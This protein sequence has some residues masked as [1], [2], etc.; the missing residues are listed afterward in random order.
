MKSLATLAIVLLF[1][2]DL[3]LS[4][5]SEASKVVFE[6]IQDDVCSYADKSYRFELYEDGDHVKTVDFTFNSSRWYAQGCFSPD[7]ELCYDCSINKA[8][9]IY[10]NDKLERSASSIE[11]EW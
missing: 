7:Y 10:Y 5:P 8:V 3:N 9:R 1:M 2:F 6:K 11:I 4:E